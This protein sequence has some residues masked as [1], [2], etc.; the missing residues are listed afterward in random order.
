MS[1]AEDFVKNFEK[2]SKVITDNAPEDLIYCVAIYARDRKDKS[3]KLLRNLPSSKVFTPD[4]KDKSYK[5]LRN[6]TL[7][8]NYTI[9]ER[10]NTML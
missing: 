3:Y 9:K 2:V 1:R 10:I 5:L 4:R 6:T 7:Y 8:D